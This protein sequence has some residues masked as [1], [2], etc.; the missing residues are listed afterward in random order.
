MAE[1]ALTT[2]ALV[3]DNGGGA[4][5]HALATAK[6]PD[7]TL[8]C[9]A[10]PSKDRTA[11]QL[12]GNDVRSSTHVAGLLTSRP[13]E[14]GYLV[15]WDV[16]SEVWASSVLKGRSPKDHVLLLTEP[17][18][19]FPELSAQQA[20]VVFEHYGFPG[21]RSVPSAALSMHGSLCSTSSGSGVP[22]PTL[23]AARACGAGIV[24]DSGFSYTHSLPVF[25]RRVVGQ[26]VKRLDAGGKVL[27]NYL[28]ELV[29][30]RSVN[31]SDM[32]HVVDACKEEVCRVCK[33]GA[34]SALQACAQKGGGSQV[35]QYVLPDGVDR[36]VGRVKAQDSE[37]SHVNAVAKEG[38]QPSPAEMK[39]RRQEEE[40]TIE[41][42]SEPFMVPEVL[43]RPMDIGLN[44]LGVAELVASSVASLPLEMREACLSNVVVCGGN[45]AISGFKE[46]LELELAPFVPSGQE[47]HVRLAP[48]D[49]VTSAWHG[50][51]AMARDKGTFYPT[52][53]TK[54][55]YE[56]EGSM[57]VLERMKASS[58]W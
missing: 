23:E 31:V 43:F 7:V 32:F 2:S 53:I 29:S 18:L 4:V 10:R 41:L 42:R 40:A 50:G 15:R 25:Q 54:R 21:Y 47:C 6:S 58:S 28:K 57:R 9:T 13:F 45:A 33:E 52:I 55:L 49:P 1:L 19:N 44:Q 12:V 26:A 8:N 38:E 20:E 16:E 51:A 39:R 30:Y 5:K 24:V 14:R 34:V 46:R 3:V 48:P 27:T 17:P 11:T 22:S 35:V 36:K 56:E 37:D